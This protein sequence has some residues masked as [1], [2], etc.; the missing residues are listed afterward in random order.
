MIINNE[1]KH[2]IGWPLNFQNEFYCGVGV[3]NIF[4]REISEAFNW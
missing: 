1:T 4:G 2:P 3:G